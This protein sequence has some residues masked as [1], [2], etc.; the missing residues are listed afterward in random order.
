MLIIEV[1]YKKPIEEVN[2]LLEAH[3]S[4]LD[5]YYD[6]GIFLASGPKEPRTGGII[7]AQTTQ[8]HI[9]TII[10]ED[11]FFINDIADYS[12][13]EFTPNKYNEKMKSILTAP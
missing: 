7:L 9:Q 3:R 8:D 5:Q 11:P 6:C 13:I 10:Q 1:K 4:F 2:Q 12:I